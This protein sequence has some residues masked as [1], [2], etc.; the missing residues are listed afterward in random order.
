M[1]TP[2]KRDKI[3]QLW[4]KRYNAKKENQGH[5]KPLCYK[6]CVIQGGWCVAV[7]CYKRLGEAEKCKA[8]LEELNPKEKYVIIGDYRG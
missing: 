2:Y 7:D 8:K 3:Q 4:L 5:D 6:V 1:N